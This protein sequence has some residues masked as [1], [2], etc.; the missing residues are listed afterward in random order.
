MERAIWRIKYFSIK[1]STIQLKGC[2]VG[3]MNPPCSQ[4]F[5]QNLELYEIKFVNH[6]LESLVEKAKAAV[7]VL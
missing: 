2:I 4:G 6:L 7:I 5:K 3:M 1:S